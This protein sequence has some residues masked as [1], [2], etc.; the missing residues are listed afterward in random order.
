MD[1]E[2]KATEE[3][4]W[5]Q[6]NKAQALWTRAK[7]EVTDEEYKEFYKHVSHDFADPL[8][9]S[10]NKVEGKMTTPAYFTFLLKRLGICSIVNISMV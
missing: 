5:E 6:I 4:K 8:V 7:S 10:H 3:T 9:W 2:G 1:E